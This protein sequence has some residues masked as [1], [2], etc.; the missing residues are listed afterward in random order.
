MKQRLNHFELSAPLYE[1]MAAF[2][3][4]TKENSSIETGLLHLVDSRV[5]QLNGCAFCVDM[6]V[7]EAKIGGERELRIH[8][9]AIWHESPLF[10]AKEKAAL[11]WAE[12]VTALGS[13]RMSEDFYNE[14]R[15]ELSEQELSDLTFAVASINSWNRLA[16]PFTV[17][18]GSADQ[19][20]GLERAGLS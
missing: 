3:I 18:P 10:S 6:H 4:A 20:F 11:A 5:S 16:I 14:V 19:M 15:D 1:K 12:A 7:K 13:G 8:H 2:S 17:P 9:V